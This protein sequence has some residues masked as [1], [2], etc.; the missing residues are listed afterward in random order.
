MAY[1]GWKRPLQETDLWTLI[2]TD[3][4]KHQIDKLELHWAAEMEKMHRYLHM[5]IYVTSKGQDKYC[6]IYLIDC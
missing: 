4:T 3:R 6:K 2:G 5:Y 1:L